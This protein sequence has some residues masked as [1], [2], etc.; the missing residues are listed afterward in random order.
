MVKRGITRNEWAVLMMGGNHREGFRWIGSDIDWI[1]WPNDHRVI[2]DK[3]K[4]G[5]NNTANT[6]LVLSDISECPPG[7]TLL[8]LLTTS[9]RE[10]K[11]L[12]CVRI[13]DRNY[14]SISKVRLLS[15]PRDFPDST[16]QGPCYIGCVAEMIEFKLASCFACDFWPPSATA[17]TDRCHSWPG[18][19]VVN[20]IVKIGC[21]F[22]A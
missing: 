17:L 5:Y 18:P 22:V 15:F 7:F 6:A 12:A 14:I 20:D 13:N 19:E 10:E 9:K 4:P 21:H 16:E 2:M 3:S 1:L 8:Q 11:D